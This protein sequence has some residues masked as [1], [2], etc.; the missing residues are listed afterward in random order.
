VEK[1]ENQRHQTPHTLVLTLF[2]SIV[3]SVPFLVLAAVV[4]SIFLLLCI[5]AFG[6]SVA[7]SLMMCA[8]LVDVVVHSSFGL[9]AQA[10]KLGID[11]DILNV[12]SLGIFVFKACPN[13]DSITFDGGNLLK[14]VGLKSFKQSFKSKVMAPL[15]VFK[16][17]TTPGVLSLI[18]AVMCTDNR[19][20]IGALNDAEA[21]VELDA[22]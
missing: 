2:K 12:K 11:A 7:I 9:L 14:V 5:S 19:L 8:E 20:K 3:A 1:A 10:L 13:C 6:D 18:L 4:V 16:L 15:P 22:P 17:K 21:L